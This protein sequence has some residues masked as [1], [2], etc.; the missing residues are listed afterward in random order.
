MTATTSGG[1]I[2][3]VADYRVVL[4]PEDT[5]V[6]TV[7]EDWAIESMAGDVFLLG[8]HTWRIRR[9]ESGT[10]RVVDADGASPTVPF[11]LGEAP[12][13]TD[14]LSLAVSLLREELERKLEVS[15]AAAVAWLKEAAGVDDRAA[16]QIVAY[17]ATAKTELGLLPTTGRLVVERFFDDTG[18]MQLVVHSPR[19]ARINRGLGLALRK[20]FC[21]S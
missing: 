17:L 16:E 4:E 18:G 3:E 7:N 2:P 14:E 11:W 10:V 19:G 8:S 12:A 1:A 20:R 9:I 6:G 13:R 5:L 21:R 15:V